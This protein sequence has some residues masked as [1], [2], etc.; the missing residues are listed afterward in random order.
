MIWQCERAFC[1]SEPEFECDD[2]FYCAVH[3][4]QLCVSMKETKV[5][6]STPDCERVAQW[7]HLV[8]DRNGER[9]GW[10]RCEEHK[11]QQCAPAASFKDEPCFV[12]S[13]TPRI[14]LTQPA[15]LALDEAS[16]L[17]SNDRRD[18]YGDAKENF[19]DIA[20]MWSA[21]KGT[22][23]EAHDV[24]AMMVLVKVSRLSVSPQK[25]DNWVDMAGYSALGAEVSD[26]K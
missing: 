26:A 22:L 8:V 12:A 3:K 15:V 20:A 1:D 21:Y 13:Q 11:C 24:A 5:E 17:V 19:T 10:L 14:T 4:C 7:R 25:W 9:M 2:H 18:V 23:F 16:E 6:C